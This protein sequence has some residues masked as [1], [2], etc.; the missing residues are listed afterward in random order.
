MTWTSTFERKGGMKAYYVW[1]FH[2]SKWDWTARNADEVQEHDETVPDNI[3]GVVITEMS[4]NSS[5]LVRDYSIRV[6][7]NYTIKDSVEVM[8]P[9][10]FQQQVKLTQGPIL[11]WLT[12]EIHFDGQIWQQTLDWDGMYKTTYEQS[13]KPENDQT[14]SDLD[15]TSTVYQKHP[16]EPGFHITQTLTMDEANGHQWISTIGC[17]FGFDND[18]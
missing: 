5:P 2:D 4:D 18:A 15:M 1:Q 14:S 16:T 10:N 13:A 7:D 3:T 6:D 11:K 17:G 12:M 8:D 9:W